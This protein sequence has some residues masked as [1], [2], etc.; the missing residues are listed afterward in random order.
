M[1]QELTPVV[2]YFEVVVLLLE[3]ELVG[4]GVDVGQVE[5]DVGGRAVRGHRVNRGV[6]VGLFEHRLAELT[7]R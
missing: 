5:G 1:H 3:V 4:G 6:E 2:H 7:S